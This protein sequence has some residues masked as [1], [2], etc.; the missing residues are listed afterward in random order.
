M[1]YWIYA[2]LAWNPEEDIDSLVKY[3]CDKAYG[4]ASEYM[5]KYYRL[6]K[7]GWNDARET[8]A[9]E[10]NCYMTY[11]TAYITIWDY[12]LNIEVDG[13]NIVEAIKDA[14]SKAYEAANDT[15]KARMQRM[16]DV[17]HNAEEVF[18]S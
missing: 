13:V 17:Y 8:M 4:D 1:T 12:F 6:L 18:L 9:L 2:K 14:L 16:I 3:Y 7:L 5:Q 15:Q 10:F 11:N